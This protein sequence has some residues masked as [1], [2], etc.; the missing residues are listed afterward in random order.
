MKN[1][2]ALRIVLTSLY[3]RKF[4]LIVVFFLNIEHVYAVI[5]FSFSN[6]LMA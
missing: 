1:S 4:E 6:D 2:V 3:D 5:Y